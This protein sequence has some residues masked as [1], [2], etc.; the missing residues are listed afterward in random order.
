MGQLSVTAIDILVVVVILVSAGYAGM[1]GLVHETFAIIEWVAA[2]YIAL[3]FTPLFQPLLRD[4]ISPP[5]LEWIVVFVATFLIAFSPLSIMSHLVSE[6][7]KKSE[8]GPI[9]RTFGFVFGLAR[10]LVIVGFAYI[11]FAALVPVRDHPDTLTKARLFPLIRN[12]SDVLRSLTPQEANAAGGNA[13]ADAKAPP[14][15]STSAKTYGA[16][17]RSALDRLF[18]TNGGEP[19]PAR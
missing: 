2:G 14:P 3:R 5:W 12:T 15:Q 13:P 10:G 11:A 4:T 9:D 18:Q 6:Q 19:T 17:D 8:I 16:D 1:R 7:V